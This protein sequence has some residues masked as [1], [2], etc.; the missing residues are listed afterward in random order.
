MF[1]RRGART[2]CAVRED[3]VSEVQFAPQCGIKLFALPQLLLQTVV[4]PP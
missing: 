2:P 4:I 3:G 1:G